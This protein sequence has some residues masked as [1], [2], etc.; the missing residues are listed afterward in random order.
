MFA[1]IA[2]SDGRIADM[3]RLV[4]SVIVATSLAMFVLVPEGGLPPLLFRAHDFAILLFGAAILVFLA[5][6][7]GAMPAVR[8]PRPALS[9][10][11]LAFAVLLLTGAGTWLVFGDYPLTR[12]EILADFDAAF[13]AQGRLIAPVPAEWRPFAPAIMHQFMLPIPAE[14]GWLSSYL[15]GNA[16]LRAFGAL[17]FGME[18]TNPILAAISILAVYRIGRRL[19]PDSPGAALVAA[20][21]MAS[22]AQFLAM[23]MTPYAMS[24]HLA[25]NLLWL[26]S[27]LRG[28][29]RGNLAAL[30]CGFIAT[31]LH[32]LVFHPLFAAPFIVHLWLAG[33]RRRALTYVAAYAAIGLFWASY[34]Q[35]VLVGAD[36]SSGQ[37][38]ANGI[39]Y[40]IGRTVDLLWTMELAA[41]PTMTFNLLRFAAWQNIVLVPLALLAWP[42]LRR[43]E[44]ISRP[45]MAGV[46]LTLVAMLV[47]MPLQGLGWGYRY[48]HGLIGNLCLLAGYGWISTAG[49]A[50]RRDF[51][52]VAG[53]ALTVLVMLPMQ[54]KLAHDF[55]APRIRIHELIAR[56][57]AEIVL[58]APAETLFDDQ[59]R[60]APDLSNRP[61][62]MDLGGLDEGRI[63]MLCS[64][65]RVALFDIRH[66]ARVGLPAN[67][68]TDQLARYSAASR[69]AACATPLPL[70]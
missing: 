59:V 54:L 22:S 1:R 14:M 35:I 60:N 25:F 44:G 56:A 20:L 64:R 16:A 10:L 63:R 57:P 34:W 27:F 50:R 17:T 37:G 58:V 30:L 5:L 21:L 43:G 51:V 15:P 53:T 39:D 12:D 62:V 28:D 11:I 67:P 29:R 45:L 40:L 55:A 38:S 13:I 8:L 65:Y 41:F 31:G 36:L 24:A 52:L 4:A 32:Q 61:I 70:D 23:A 47:L 6:G 42:A 68:S 7:S 26:W 48:V 3:L 19:W 33:E 9:V 2:R 46:L 69:R 18:W 49:E 66:G